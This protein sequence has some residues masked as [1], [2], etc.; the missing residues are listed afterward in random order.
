VLRI[1]RSS[2]TLGQGLFEDERCV[3]TAE[4]VTVRLDPETGR[5][6]PLSEALRAAL[7]SA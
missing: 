2:Y 6:A 3:A 4:V 5:A 7:E 1:G